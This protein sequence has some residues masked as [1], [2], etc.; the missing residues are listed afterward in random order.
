MNLL[1]RITL[2]FPLCAILLSIVAYFYA[3]VFSGFK[4]LIIPLLMMIML[5][6]GMTL[7]WND[8]RQIFQN[9]RIIGLGVLLQYSIMPLTAFLLSVLFNLP[10]ELMIGMVLVGSSSGGTASNV[11]CYLAKGNVALSVTMTLVSTLLVVLLLPFFSWLFLAQMVEVPVIDMLLN[12]VKLVLL[13]VAAG[14]AVN[15]LLENRIQQ[16]QPVFPLVA[17]A[18]IVFII[19]IIVGLNKSNLALVEM[20]LLAAV[21]LHNGTGLLLGY[22][23]VRWLGF[24]AK[25][26]RTVAI[27]VGMQNSGLS[28]ALAVKYF[29]VL[30]ALPGALFSIWH[31]LTGS[32]LASIWAQKHRD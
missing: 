14:V 6:M 25:T 13:P 16:L 23:L 24:D 32:I 15:T 28:V 10:P 19:A 2:L 22:Q 26:A 1:S 5:S 12:L 21:V 29:G 8:F 20:S 30:S 27:E 4:F 18:S 31:N 17:V 7:H 11:I 3:D 9:P